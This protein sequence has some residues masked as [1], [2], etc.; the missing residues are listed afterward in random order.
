MTEPVNS[1]GRRF[2]QA[3]QFLRMCLLDETFPITP[4]VSCLAEETQPGRWTVR[5]V[6]QVIDFAA[7]EEFSD[8]DLRRVFGAWSTWARHQALEIASLLPV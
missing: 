6:W 2:P 3:H 5:L 4:S 8:E 1:L 7:S